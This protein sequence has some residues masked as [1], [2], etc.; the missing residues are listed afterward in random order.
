MCYGFLANPL[1]IMFH[2]IQAPDR[3]LTLTRHGSYALTFTIPKGAGD[4]IIAM[5]KAQRNT[6]ANIV[7]N[8]LADALAA[9]VTKKRGT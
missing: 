1:G 4:Q 7:R 6:A 9:A 8:I 3:G 2:P 5:A